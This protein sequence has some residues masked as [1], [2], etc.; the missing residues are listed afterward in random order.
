MPPVIETGWAAPMLLCGAM[1]ATSAA[2]VMKQPA[3][4]AFAPEG[5]TKITVGTAEP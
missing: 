3:L 4:A 5:V 2:N 1:A